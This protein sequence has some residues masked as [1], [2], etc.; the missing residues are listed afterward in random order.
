MTKIITG[1]HKY[2]ENFPYK[3]EEGIQF[4]A[5]H[6]ERDE[7]INFPLDYNAC[8]N[9]EFRFNPEKP[10]LKSGFEICFKEKLNLSSEDLIQPSIM[11]I[12]NF[13]SGK[14]LFNEERIFF[15]KQL[16]KEMYPLK[17]GHG[18]LSNKE[19][20]W[21]QIEKNVKKDNTIF[22]LKNELKEEM[23]K[24]VFP[25]HF[26][27]FETSAVALPFNKGRKPYEQVAFQFSHHRVNEDGTIE[28]ANEFILH[29]A[30][31]FPNFEFV[32][33]L[34]KALGD[35][36]TIFRYSTHE[37]SILNAIYVQLKESK[38]NDKQ[39]LMDFIK[40]ISQ[41]KNVS[42]EM[43]KGD[44]NMVD[45]CDIYKKYYF[46]PRTNGSNSIKAVLPALLKRSEFLQTKYVQP[47]GEIGVTSKN[48]EDS[49][50]WLTYKNEEIQNPYKQLPP[51]FEEWNED[52][53][54]QLVSDMEDLNNGGAAL[55]AYGFLQ[56]TDMSE[57]ERQTL[58]KA[59]LK[60]CELDTLAMVMI[61]EHFREV[62]DKVK[63]KY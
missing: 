62:I 60:Y 13:R 21:L 18:L 39:P 46:D 61:W 37:N 20:Q 17:V 38:E 56:Y 48:F 55:T 42:S 26:I 24:W 52:Q 33:A 28:H 19:R 15:M 59:L 2:S 12:W 43:W 23:E 36:G 49:H 51:V 6:Y 35:K 22:V 16:T 50:I 3:F 14:K 45:L 4:L 7:K 63:E 40:T 27:D 54:D 57:T 41:S 11:D 44:R 34:K 1:K 53:L 58:V 30:G 5:D 8:K 32:R 31:K 47:I 10:D 25:L 29:E 9:C